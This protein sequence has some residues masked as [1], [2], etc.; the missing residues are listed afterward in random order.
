[1]LQ[2]DC[3]GVIMHKAMSGIFVVIAG[4]TFFQ[5]DFRRV[6]PVEVV[7][8]VRQ[9]IFFIHGQDDPVV[10]A[11]ESVLL[12]DVS[13]NPEDKIW[14]VPNAEHVNIYSKMPDEYVKRVTQFFERNIR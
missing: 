12:H 7:D 2:L 8:Q 1:M 9:P 13:D 14:I 3:C 11:E 4:H 5:T 6:R 10:P